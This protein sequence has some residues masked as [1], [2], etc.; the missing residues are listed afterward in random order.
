MKTLA[1]LAAITVSTVSVAFGQVKFNNDAYR[2]GEELVYRVHYGFID[3]GTATLSVKD[4]E[5]KFAD[6]NTYHVV[7]TAKTNSAFDLFFKMRDRYET[8]IDQQTLAPWFFYRTIDEGGYKYTESHLFNPATK[9]VI[10]KTKSY[11]TP[12]NVQDMFSIF[13][14]A[15]S[16]D[17][18]NAKIGDV[19]TLPYFMTDQTYEMKIKYAG[20]ETIK[21]EL[22]KFTCLKFHPMMEK[23][24]VF[25]EEEDV[26]MWLTDDKNHIPVRAQA[27]ILVGSVKIDLQSYKG[28]ANTLAMLK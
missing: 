23:G 24:R 19:Y 7:G 27:N 5:R 10:N 25:K 26:T 1:K 6:R 16:L 20:K 21:T 9:T 18:S 17:L 15:R 8:Y 4:E 22:G 2:V 13:Y 3:A 14:Y 11:E 12:A 28:L